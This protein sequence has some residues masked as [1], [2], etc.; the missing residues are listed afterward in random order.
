MNPKQL[1]GAVLLL[2]VIG[3]TLP[4]QKFQFAL[5]GGYQFGATVDE[6]TQME[7]VFSWN[8]ALGISGSGSYGV[9]FDMRLLPKMKL[10]LSWDRQPTQLNFHEGLINTPPDQT[11]DERPVTKLSDLNVD[12][13]LVGLIYDWSP[14]SLKPFIGA[15]VGMVRMVPEENYQTESRFTFAPIVG[16]QLYVSSLF[17]FRAHARFMV[18]NVPEGELF[19]S[20]ADESFRYHHHKDTFMIQ[21][22]VGGGVVLSF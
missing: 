6:T 20:T 13:Y 22:Q 18:G 7:G 10:E 15:S 8:E 17:A 1:V 5:V 11:S 14:N 4:A 19:S 9:V 12:Y 16:L 3:S 2:M 21:Y